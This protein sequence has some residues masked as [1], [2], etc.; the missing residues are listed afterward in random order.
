M[1]DPNLDYRPMFGNAVGSTLVTAL[2]ARARGA[3]SAGVT[4]WD[5]PQARQAWEALDVLATEHGI[6]L[7]DLTLTDTMN[8]VGTIRRSQD[9]DARV[10]EFAAQHGHIRVVSLGVG[11]CNRAARL[12]DLDAEWFGV[13]SPE[14]I[15]LRAAVLPHDVTRR[16]SGSVTERGWLSEIEPGPPTVFV[17]EGLLMYLTRAQTGQLLTRVGD[18]M[19]GPTRIVADLHHSLVAKPTAPI[20]ALTGADFHSGT[21]SPRALAELSP[22]WRLHATDPTMARISPAAA[23]VSRIFRA[24]SGNPMYSVITIE[25]SRE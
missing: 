3:E 17:A 15:S 18:H 4:D 10:R 21:T 7:H 13:D 23:V 2:Y 22:G 14:V 12:A 5:D 11:L 1:T 25:R 9:M 8:V 16:A 20:A 24:V 19:T 6:T